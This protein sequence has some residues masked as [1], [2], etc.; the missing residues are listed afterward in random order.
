MSK[1]RNLP[2][3]ELDLQ[4]VSGDEG[5]VTEGEQCAQI[6]TPPEEIRRNTTS[7]KLSKQKSGTILVKQKRSETTHITIHERKICDRLFRSNISQG[8]LV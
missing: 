1:R 5:P 3:K 6:S 2:A 4:P 7:S 8:T